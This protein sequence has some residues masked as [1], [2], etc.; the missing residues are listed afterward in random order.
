MYVVI[1]QRLLHFWW[2]Q[3]GDD[4]LQSTRS[5]RRTNTQ[6]VVVC[7]S[8]E[9]PREGS[10]TTAALR[11]HT[12][13]G[14]QSPDP[15]AEGAAVHGPVFVFNSHSIAKP[16]WHVHCSVVQKGGLQPVLLPLDPW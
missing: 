6:V 10:W 11:S 14:A 15:H 2:Q 16:R 1:Y 7:S 9:I 12:A 13:H 8:P 5:V 3:N 4:R